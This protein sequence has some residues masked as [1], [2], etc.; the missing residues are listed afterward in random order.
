MARTTYKNFNITATYIGGEKAPWSDEKGAPA[1]YNNHRVTVYSKETKTRISFKFWASQMHPELRSRADLLGAFHCFL[2]DAI[3][4]SLV[5]GEFCREYGYNDDSR[6]AEKVWRLCQKS[7]TKAV[8]LLGDQDI[9]DLTN[10]L[11][12]EL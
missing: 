6:R 12:Q 7:L 3:S 2:E 11:S 1:N 8:R 4:G 9:Y 10:G 5:F